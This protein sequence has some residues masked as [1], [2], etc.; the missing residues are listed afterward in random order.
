LDDVAKEV[1]LTHM[2]KS[3][4]IVMVSTGTIGPEARRYAQTVMKNS[5][6]AIILID[7]EDI[8]MVSETP[9]TIIDI[10]RREAKNAMRPKK[11]EL[12]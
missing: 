6:L 12:K 2:L 7:R 9:P 10:L 11:L 3:N 5:N 1:G 4:A 8:D